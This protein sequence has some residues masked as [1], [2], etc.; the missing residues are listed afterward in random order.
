MRI[1]FKLFS[2]RPF[3]KRFE[4]FISFIYGDL[5]LRKNPKSSYD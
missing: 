5:R 4:F 1:V 3:Y 2:Y